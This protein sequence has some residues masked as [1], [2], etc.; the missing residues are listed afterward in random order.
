[1]SNP[2]ATITLHRTV[3]ATDSASTAIGYT[4][5]SRYDAVS[6]VPRNFSDYLIAA[7]LARRA[8]PPD[9]QAETTPVPD[10]RCTR[11]VR[12]GTA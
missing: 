2:I 4:G 6:H 1:M 12:Y 3:T 8:R 5:G 11:S 9:L 7:W 10:R